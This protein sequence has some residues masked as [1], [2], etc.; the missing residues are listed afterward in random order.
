M[1]REKGSGKKSGTVHK[2]SKV[3]PRQQKD[4]SLDD[5]P[6]RLSRK[7]DFDE[8]D[9]MSTPQRKA[10]GPQKKRRRSHSSSAT[11]PQTPDVSVAIDIE[12]LEKD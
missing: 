6:E 1:S 3:H 12:R 10:S 11:P 7:P 9:R 2:S 5:L 4:H 8:R